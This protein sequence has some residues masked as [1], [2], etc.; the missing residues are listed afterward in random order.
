MALVPLVTGISVVNTATP[1]IGPPAIIF[2][3]VPLNP[4]AASITSLK[5]VPIGTK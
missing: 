1:I 4:P 2:S 5:L 3:G